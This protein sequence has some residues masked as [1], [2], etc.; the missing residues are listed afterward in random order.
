MGVGVKVG[1]R[2]YFFLLLGR[3]SVWC[4]LSSLICV[5]I[6]KMKRKR[7][8]FLVSLMKSYFRLH[9]PFSSVYV[10]LFFGSEML[11]RCVFADRGGEGG[12]EDNSEF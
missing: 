8:I 11:L 3:E 6:Q 5:Y 7:L 9:S 2:D 12:E 10:R 1:F 4:C